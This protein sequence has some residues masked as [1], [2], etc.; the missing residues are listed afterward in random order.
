MRRLIPLMR[1]L[2]IGETTRRAL[3]ESLSD[4]WHEAHAVSGFAA[5]SMRW[6]QTCAAVARIVAS[7]VSILDQE[8]PMSQ[9]ANDL[10]YALRR[11]RR[12]PTFAIFSILTLGLGIGATTAIYSVIHAAQSP[13]PAVTNVERIVNVYH[14]RGGSLPMLSLSWQDFTDFRARQTVFAKV[15]GWHHE[16]FAFAAAGRAESGFGEFVTGDYFDVLGV[17]VALGRTI[18]PADDQRNAPAV[19]VISHRVW[20]RLFDEAPDVIGRTLRLNGVPAQIVGVAPQEF[21]GLFNGGIVSSAVWVPFSNLPRLGTARAGQMDDRRAR[22]VLVKGLLRSDRTV[23]QVSVEAELIGRQLDLESPLA[24]PGDDPRLSSSY[25]TRRWHVRRAA[26]IVIN[27]GMERIVRPLT[28]TLLLAVSL[29]LMVVCTNLANMTLAR[30]TDR[31]HELAIRLALGASRWRLVREQIVESAVVVLAGATAG[32]ALARVAMVILS[33]ELAVGNGVTIRMVPRL[34]VAVLIAASI[35]AGLALVVAG[36]IPALQSVRADLRSP[37]SSSGGTSGVP[38]WRWRRL[39]I[40]SQVT[41]SL[42][43]VT[44]AAL[45]I[46]HVREGLGQ[47]RGL[48]LAAIAVAEVDFGTQQYDPERTRSIANAIVSRL[49]QQPDVDAVAMSSGWP[50]LISDPGGTVLQPGTRTGASAAFVA[51]SPTILDALGL[52]LIV[53]RKFDARDTVGAPRVV[54]LSQ[55]TAQVLFDDAPAIGREVEV[56]RRQWVGEPEPRPFLATVVGIAGD[57]ADAGGPENAVYLPIDQH[58]ERRL[59]FT[60][61]ANGDPSRMLTTIRQTIAGVDPALAIGQLTT[62]PSLVGTEFL[63]FRVMGAI[64]AILGLFALILALAGLYGVLSHV[65]GRRTRE[66]GIRI[67]LGA[68]TARILRMVIRDGL[69][70]VISGLVL[71]LAIGGIARMSLGPMFTRLAPAIDPVVLTSVPLA[72]IAAAVVAAYV[73]A[74]RAA[75]IDPNVALR[76]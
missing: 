72:M 37:M 40:A 26:D 56:K 7:A 51:G 42:V 59:T 45:C 30:A 46:S 9:F 39:L 74:R 66:I 38:R 73:P 18:Q 17:P 13:P 60:V 62:G 31:T 16:R 5:K 10:R 65:I 67:A 3:D 36:I 43:L 55:R 29:V 64:A 28:A 23:E 35:A 44:L 47:D 15:M 12:A 68:D 54:I 25:F 11:L 53:G 76:D 20:Q 70:P 63:F 52:P 48:D 41:V 14:S 1:W 22:I 61:R 2:P 58:P 8:H 24:R 49:S 21:S 69:E 71:G 32:V 19:V 75:K 33:R 4:G 27:E 57:V 6:L 34:D 50:V